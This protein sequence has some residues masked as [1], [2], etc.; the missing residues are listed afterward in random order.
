MDFLKK[1]YTNSYG[2]DHFGL[3]LTRLRIENCNILDFYIYRNN[4]EIFEDV[5]S[6]VRVIFGEGN[7]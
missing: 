2:N 1:K 7:V 6:K 5:L 3:I 4:E